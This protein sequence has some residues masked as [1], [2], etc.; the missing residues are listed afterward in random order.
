MGYV[1]NLLG[2]PESVLV[3]WLE[4]VDV[5]EHVDPR[6]PVR[7]LLATCLASMHFSEVLYYSGCVGSGVVFMI[8][9][10]GCCWRNDRTAGRRMS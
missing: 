9:P 7:V 8:T 6:C 5:V 1:A 3:I 2:E 10:R 4:G